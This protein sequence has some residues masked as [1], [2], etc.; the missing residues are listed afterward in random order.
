MSKEQVVRELHKPARRNF[1]RRR[2]IIKGFDDL[3]QA[4]LAEFIPYARDNRGH[5]YILVV[6]DCY[7]KYVFTRPLKSKTSGEVVKAMSSIFKNSGGRVP[8]NLQTDQGK[9]FY[10]RDFSKLMKQYDINH[11]SSFSVI[12]ASI[13]E[14]AIRSIKNNLYREFSLRGK[15]KWIDILGDVTQKYNTSKHR[16]IGMKPA[17]VHSNTPRLKVYDNLKIFDKRRVRYKVGDIVK[18]SKHKSV[19]SRGFHGSWTPENF[20]IV[21]IQITNPPTYILQDLNGQPIAGGFYEQEL[22]KT[23][24]PDVYLVEKVLRRKGNKVYVKWLGMNERSWIDKDNVVH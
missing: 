23:K 13:A 22:Q 15:Y 18:I 17:D 3:W 14:R 19:F 4:D 5:K 20:K 10:N 1:P 2:T 12:K 8:R 6:I 7:S 11:Y 24:H 21:K 16:T 9:E